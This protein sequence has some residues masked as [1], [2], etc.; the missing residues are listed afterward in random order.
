MNKIIYKIM[1]DENDNHALYQQLYKK[2]HG[3]EDDLAKQIHKQKI[4]FAKFIQKELELEK[5]E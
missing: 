3:H 2:Y 5:Q 4:E 1:T